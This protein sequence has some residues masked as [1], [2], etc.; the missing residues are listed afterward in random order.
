M[1]DIVKSSR[2]FNSWA[3]ESQANYEHYF[4][5]GDRSSQNETKLE[6]QK[7][8][9]INSGGNCQMRSFTK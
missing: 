8:R 9:Y 6:K 1:I 2:F 7:Y 5:N 3:S 4:P